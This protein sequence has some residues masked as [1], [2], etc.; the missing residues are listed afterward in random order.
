MG[1]ILDDFYGSN[2]QNIKKILYF[3]ANLELFLANLA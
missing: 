3:L 2:F 1:T